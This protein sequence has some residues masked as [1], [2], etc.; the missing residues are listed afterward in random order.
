MCKDKKSFDITQFN[1]GLYLRFDRMTLPFDKHTGGKK[2]YPSGVEKGICRLIPELWLGAN[3]IIA[4]R[5][6]SHWAY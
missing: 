1:H 2:C 4:L 5:A 3:K 6:M